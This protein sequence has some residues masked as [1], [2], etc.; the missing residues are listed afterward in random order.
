M[1]AVIKKKSPLRRACRRLGWT[2][3]SCYGAGVL[4]LLTFFTAFL[5][6]RRP[7]WLDMVL[8]LL[9]GLSLVAG[10]VLSGKRQVLRAGLQGEDAAAETV[11]LLP[12]QYRCYQNLTVS[13]KG[14]TSEM[15][16]VITGPTGIFIVEVKHQNG[17]VSGGYEDLR[18]V[19]EKVGRKGGSY[20]KH[21]YNPL[22]QVSTH[23][24]RLAN[25]LRSRGLNTHIS[26]MVYFSNPGTELHL[27]GK[28]KDIP[29]FT[30]G[31]DGGRALCKA[32]TKNADRVPAK[33]LREINRQLDRL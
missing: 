24:Y 31:C 9:F 14:K 5:G 8:V 22:K 23:T 16:L 2:V 26:S 33:V 30:E 29:V 6:L 32:I 7:S 18:W 4:S 19:Q 10:T 17:T 15:D 27:K 21:F 1:A 20:K 11:S 25:W 3:I 13:H 12:E 28:P